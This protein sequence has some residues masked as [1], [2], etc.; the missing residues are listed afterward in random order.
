LT[1]NLS[2]AQWELI[3]ADLN[4]ILT[5]TDNYKELRGALR[6]WLDVYGD[7][8]SGYRVSKD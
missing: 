7:L 5:Q 2:E 4:N 3:E 8:N 6:D 1:Q